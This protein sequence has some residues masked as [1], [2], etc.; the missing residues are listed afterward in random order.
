MFLWDTIH[1]K[2]QKLS[3]SVLSEA[4]KSRYVPAILSLSVSLPVISVVNHILK[5]NDI[6]IT[7][8]VCGSLIFA[9]IDLKLYGRT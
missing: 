4:V 1:E 2:T 8:Y 3:M 6:I 5:C 7:H 9:L